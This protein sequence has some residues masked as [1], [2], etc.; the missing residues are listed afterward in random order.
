M[1]L[2]LGASAIHAQEPIVSSDDGVTLNLRNTE[3]QTLIT[4]MADL[5]G[6]NFVVDPRVQGSV[7]VVSSAPT[8]PDGLYEVF[9]SILKVHGFAAVEAGAVTKIIPDA[10]A[11]QEGAPREYSGFSERQ[12]NAVIMLAHVD[13]NEMVGVLRPL[14]P[15]EAHLA[16][17]L[18]ANALVF[19]D[20]SA[21]IDRLLRIVRKLDLPANSEFEVVRL[22]HAQ[23]E[24]IV[25]TIASFL[26]ST[27][28]R[29]GQNISPPVIADTRT[30]RLILAG[31]KED[32]LFYRGLIA[33]LD[34][35]AAVADNSIDVVFLEFASAETLVEI[36]QTVGERISRESG[37]A[38]NT[39]RPA[40]GGNS[41]FLV[42][43][44][45]ANN[46]II[47]HA[48]P[49]VL[50]ALR[51]VIRKLD[52]RRAQVLVEGIVAE[53]SSNKSDELGIQWQ[54]SIQSDGYFAGTRLPGVTSGGIPDPFV[55]NSGPSLL[56]GLTVGYFSQQNLRALIR[57]LSGDQYTNVLSTPTL[58][59][60]DNAE[61][62]IVVGQN[63]PF[64]TGQFTNNSTTPDNPFQTIERQDVGIVLKVKP[65]IN[66]GDSVTLEIEQE[67]SSVDRDSVGSDLITNK[68]SI[69]TT[70]LVKDQ[71]VVVLGGLISDDVTENTQKIPLLGDI[72]V[73]GQLFRN[74]QSDHVKTNLMVFLRPAIIRDD[75]TNRKLV[76][77][78]YEDIRT[79]Q[80]EQEELSRFFLRDPGAELPPLDIQQ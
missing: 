52:V 77:S 72:P 37:G 22:E 14:M 23:A 65:Q 66:A 20:T 4:A 12:S 28:V 10:T 57:T 56:N 54:T 35:P 55:E 34:Q 67:V 30:N 16:A 33:E 42:Q 49:P 71:E 75:E 1:A 25:R 17:M 18:T 76:R 53:V 79:K 24:D 62:E 46:A 19:A 21:N 13:A 50:K 9:L 74:D 45:P 61:A 47:L 68:R 48:P 78:R 5:T 6:R 11:R 73:L 26:T 41:N 2:L 15:Q 51:E 70:V 39:Q 58:V 29:P 64:I 31:A 40:G 63:V 60:L 27:S 7:T 32:R 80:K 3:I 36:L 38:Q 8:D 43:A 44:D 69:T 59:T